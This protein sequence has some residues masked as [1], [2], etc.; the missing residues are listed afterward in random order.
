MLQDQKTKHLVVRYRLRTDDRQ[1]ASIVTAV[2]GGVKLMEE[3][4]PHLKVTAWLESPV[5]PDVQS[6][7]DERIS[8]FSKQR[9]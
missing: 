1:V 6:A 7:I 3:A 5:P 8:E 9:D 4:Y 2:L